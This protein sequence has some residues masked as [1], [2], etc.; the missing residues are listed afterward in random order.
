V[1]RP[2]APAPTGPGRAAPWG[3][4]GHVD[5]TALLEAWDPDEEATD[6][7]L[8]PA[9]LQLAREAGL[10]VAFG[11]YEDDD[12]VVDVAG[13]PLAVHD[14]AV[15]LQCADCDDLHHL[16]FE[17]IAWVEL[18]DPGP[19]VGADIDWSGRGRAERGGGVAPTSRTNGAGSARR[20]GR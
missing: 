2:R 6:P 3:R 1:T 5:R 18:L 12:E 8:Y 17:E 16:G 14:G 10:A 13:T 7:A 11:V 9:L 19:D 20:R 15:T 4:G